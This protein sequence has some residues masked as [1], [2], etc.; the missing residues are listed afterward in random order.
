MRGTLMACGACGVH[1]QAVA[2]SACIL[3][4]ARHVVPVVEGALQMDA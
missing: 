4:G 2:K 1:E 3:E